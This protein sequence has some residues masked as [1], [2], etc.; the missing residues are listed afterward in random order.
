MHGSFSHGESAFAAQ[1]EL[2]SEFRLVVP[3]RRGFG[4]SPGD[5][6]VDFERDAEDIVT[7]LGDGAHLVGH[8]Y[9]GVVCLLAAA[10]RP[11]AVLS[12]CVIEPPCFGVAR[13]H[14]AVEEMIERVARH[15]AS[16]AGA[17][18]AEYLAGFMR[19]WGLPARAAVAPDARTERSWRASSDERP[20]WEAEIPLA[21]LRA[22][23]FAK[24]VVSGGWSRVP[25]EARE[26]AGAAF[27]AVCDVLER[28]LGASRARFSEASHNPQALGA[29]FNARLLELWRAGT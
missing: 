15:H 19:S 1:R 25:A 26:I 24:L 10:L 8:S 5:G 17:S 22:A 3:D 20:P 16:A 12:L 13:G 23:P 14:P 4:D 11:E 18:P 6:R 9:G 29:P 28:G 2:A 7:L 27:E 21:A